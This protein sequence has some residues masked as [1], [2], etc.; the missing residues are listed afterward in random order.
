MRKIIAAVVASCLLM[1]GC[2]SSVQKEEIELLEPVN[3]KVDSTY[4]TR[5][6]MKDMRLFDGRVIPNTDELSFE[7]NGFISDIFV[8][9]GDR[10]YK[11]DIIA[12]LKSDHYDEIEELRDEIETLT[13]E[14]AKESERLEN[15]LEIARL[16]GGDTEEKE[17]EIRHKE[18]LSTLEL[19]LKKERLDILSENDFGYAYIEAP[20]DSTVVAVTTTMEGGFVSAGTPVVALDNGKSPIITCEFVSEANMSVIERAYCTVRGKEYDLT[21][22]PYDKTDLKI[23]VT[24]E[25][26]P[27]SRF[28]ITDE[29]YEGMYVGDYA[30][31]T[32]LKSVKPN[33]LAVPVNAVYSDSAGKFVYEVA[34]GQRIRRDVVTG[35]SDSVYV[36]ILEG[37]REGTCIYVKN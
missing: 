13:K 35:I 26:V 28:S 24:N 20:Y 27:V 3:A 23:M 25:I 33:V 16:N 8:A 1:T 17:L 9:P 14:N 12:G 29:N 7:Y 11:G 22:I 36:E 10:V 34:D 32:I 30:S 37:I 21:Y 4:V 18:E 2:G 19:S 5:T 31:V 6:D 15:E